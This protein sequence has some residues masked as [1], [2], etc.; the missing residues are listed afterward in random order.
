MNLL[1]KILERLHG[2]TVYLPYLN[3]EI[4]DENTRQINANLVIQQNF[5]KEAALK[6]KEIPEDLALVN[7]KLDT[8][9][10]KVNQKELEIVERVSPKVKKISFPTPC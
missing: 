3:Q 6:K 7:S 1:K 5:L 10:D 8:L 2:K 9:I 4:V